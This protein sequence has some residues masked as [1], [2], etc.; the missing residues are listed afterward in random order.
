MEIKVIED[1]QSMLRVLVTI[2]KRKLAK[3]KHLTLSREQILQEVKNQNTK[4]GSN[5]KCI[6][7]PSQMNNWGRD[8][9]LLEAEYTFTKN[10]KPAVVKT[11][12]S[13]RKTTKKTSKRTTSVKPTSTTN[14]TPTTERTT[15]KED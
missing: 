14:S 7:G 15:T 11:L 4:L 5:I 1:N 3:D 2:P 13:T 12:T 8:N 10:K 9:I 6:G